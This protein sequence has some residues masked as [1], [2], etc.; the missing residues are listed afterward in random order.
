LRFVVITS[1][2]TLLSI[3]ICRSLF[4][5]E[6]KLPKEHY[7]FALNSVVKARAVFRLNSSKPVLKL[8]EAELLQADSE[9]GTI[10]KG[11]CVVKLA[12]ALSNLDFGL[13]V[14]WHAL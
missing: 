10:A 6:F 11:T 7:N 14:G 8:P 5:T 1:L 12:S 2:D 4:N 3:D 9:K 13:G